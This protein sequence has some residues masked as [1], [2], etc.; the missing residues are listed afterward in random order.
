MG[1]FGLFQHQNDVIFTRFDQFEHILTQLAPLKY[2]KPHKSVYIL[3]HISKGKNLKVKL[4]HSFSLFGNYDPFLH[5][6]DVILT[7]FALFE[8]HFDSKEAKT[9]KK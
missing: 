4:F 7:R 5:Q 1:V 2:F 8:H 9:S 6:N 3:V